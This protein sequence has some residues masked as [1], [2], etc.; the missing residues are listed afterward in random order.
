MDENERSLVENN[1]PGI[2]VRNGTIQASAPS[3]IFTT[4]AALE[5]ED[6]SEESNTVSSRRKQVW[7]ALSDSQLDDGITFITERRGTIRDLELWS[8]ITETWLNPRE[9]DR[10]RLG[11]ADG[12]EMVQLQ[13]NDPSMP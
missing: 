3:Q 6:E 9:D 10:R 11:I 7:A 5:E 13:V 8:F 12:Y 2:V 1:G 4:N